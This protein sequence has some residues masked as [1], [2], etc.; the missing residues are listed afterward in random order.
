MSEIRY[1][2]TRGGT[3]EAGFEE[4]LLGGLAP[5]GGLWL[6]KT[7]PRFA[8]QDFQAMQGIYV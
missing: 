5:D 7:W 3:D 8:A 6:P 4:I 2:S 1:V